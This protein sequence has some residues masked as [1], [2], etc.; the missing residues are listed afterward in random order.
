M[1]ARE[2]KS[3]LRD[4]L[5]KCDCAT[6]IDELIVYKYGNLKKANHYQHDLIAGDIDFSKTPPTVRYVVKCFKHL[7]IYAAWPQGVCRGNGK[8]IAYKK[9]LI[10]MEQNP[11]CCYTETTLD[12]DITMCWFRGE[13]GVERFIKERLLRE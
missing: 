10:A 4:C 3:F 2:G 5:Q 11:D 13:V 12:R 9:D 7:G 8:C 6:D 1:T